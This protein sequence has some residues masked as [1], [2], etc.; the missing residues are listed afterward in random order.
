MKNALILLTFLVMNLAFTN[1]FAVT[2]EQAVQSAVE[3]NESVAQSWSQLQQS[4]EY[5]RQ[6]RGNIF[7]TLT[8]EGSY[9][10]QPKLSDPIAAN[11]FPE[12]QTH[13]HTAQVE[14]LPQFVLEIILIRLLYIIRKIAEECK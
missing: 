3:K 11:F 8:L 12:E 13:R 9:L 4:E 5:V 1:V 7:P 6:I 10:R 14:L 2:L